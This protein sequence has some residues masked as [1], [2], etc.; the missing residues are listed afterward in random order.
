MIRLA[1]DRLDSFVNDMLMM[2]KMEQSKLRLNAS[3]V[4]INQLALDAERHF[5]II[6][7]SKG[8]ALTLELPTPPLE[9]YLD[10]NLLRRVIG[11]LLANA[12]QY[13]PSDT[14][15]TL[16]VKTKQDAAGHLHLQMQVID[17]GPGIPEE[18][19]SRVFEK[20]EVIDLKRKGVPQIGLGLTFC[21]MVVE[22]HGGKIFVEPN[23]PQ[24]SI[25]VVE[26]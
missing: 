9:I 1:A 25:F 5:S 2:A 20:F 3:L 22:A 19:R 8:I 14:Q 26:I 15:V 21:K 12:L 24:G 11:N 4:D 16:R 10:S 23:T 6:A 17:Q 13:S 18:Y 7:H